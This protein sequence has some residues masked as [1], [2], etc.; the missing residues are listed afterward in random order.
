MDVECIDQY[1]FIKCIEQHVS[2]DHFKD[3]TDRKLINDI[4]RGQLTTFQ[5]AADKYTKGNVEKITTRL[6][7][8]RNKYLKILLSKRVYHNDIQRMKAGV[9]AGWQIVR[10]MLHAGF[11]KGAI[12]RA[13]KIYE[14]AMYCQSYDIASFIAADLS[15]HYARGGEDF[16]KAIYWHGH[17]DQLIDTFTIIDDARHYCDHIRFISRNTTGDESDLQKVEALFEKLAFH[18]DCDAHMYWHCYYMAKIS[19]CELKK[20]YRALRDTSLKAYKYY[21][22]LPFDYSDTKCALLANVVHGENSLHRYS[23]VAQYKEH[24]KDTERPNASILALRLARSFINL[25]DMEEAQQ[26]LT[27]IKSHPKVLE[28]VNL[29]RSYATGRYHDHE[30]KTP[31]LKIAYLIAELY[32]DFLMGEIEKYTKDYLLKFIKLHDLV[33]TKEGVLIEIFAL[34]RYQ[35]IDSRQYAEIFELQSTISYRPSFSAEA[36]VLRFESIVAQLVI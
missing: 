24:L 22:G 29:Y 7:R 21:E 9:G 26:L 33:D 31:E 16:S 20:D 19:I 30:A 5:E 18:K 13:H 4:A 34:L 8:I 17:R 1:S 6:D 36:E 12:E 35:N 3:A 10:D 25:G 15:H 14:L 27:G 23:K 32:C 11:R 2:V 28:K